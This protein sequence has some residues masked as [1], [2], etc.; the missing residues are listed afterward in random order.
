MAQP[1]LYLAVSEKERVTLLAALRWWQRAL[2]I[3]GDRDADKFNFETEFDEE[4]HYDRE[5]KSLDECLTIARLQGKF[6]EG[7]F[8]GEDPETSCS[9]VEVEQMCKVLESQE[10]KCDGK[11]E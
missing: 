10:G 11:V 6:G 1:K 3:V 9:I 5:C 2:T 8:W 4:Q 7:G